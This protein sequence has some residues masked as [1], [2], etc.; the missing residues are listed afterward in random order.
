VKRSDRLYSLYLDKKQLEELRRL[1][2]SLKKK[3]AVEV[4]G[5]KFSVSYRLPFPNLR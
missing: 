4:N 1:L 2:S 3:Q 5:R